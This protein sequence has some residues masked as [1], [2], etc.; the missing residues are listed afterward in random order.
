MYRTFIRMAQAAMLA[1]LLATTLLSAAPNAPVADAAERRD[2]DAVAALLKQA[3]D[4]NA[5]QGDGMTALHWAAINDDTALA[6]MLLFAGANPKAKTRIGGYT[7]LMLAAT[8]GHAAVLK[9]LVEAGTDVNATA[10]N[11]TTALMF[12]AAS[13]DVG[14]VEALIAHG[15]DLDAR[16]STRGLTAAMFAAGADRAGVIR[17][18]G[19]H[20]A[21]LKAASTATDL[22]VIDRSAFAGVLFGNPEP[23]KTPGGQ[24]G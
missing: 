3:A 21:D 15:A 7:P 2:K 5:P 18:L 4:V 6:S 8:N 24:A 12:A 14:S 19:T 22:R 17:A 11:G 16:E 10:A 1:A 9:R 13:G 20:G 23:P